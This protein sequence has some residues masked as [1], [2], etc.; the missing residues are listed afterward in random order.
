MTDQLEQPFLDAIIRAPDNDELRRVYADFLEERGDARADLIR[1]QLAGENVERLLEANWQTYA[2]ELAPWTD[3]DSFSRGLVDQVTMTPEQIIE[4]SERVFSRHP[5]QTLKVEVST[6]NAAQ[7]GGAPALSRVR[8]LLLHHETY[9]FPVAAPRPL[10]GIVKGTHFDALRALHFMFCGFDGA[11]WEAFFSELE[12]PLLERLQFDFNRSHP[13]MW[14]ALARNPSLQNLESI[15]EYVTREL[16]GATASGFGAAMHDFAEKKPKLKRL[17]LSQVRT[18]DEANNG[19]NA[20]SSSVV[21]LRE[22]EIDGAK[23]TDA[24]LVNWQRGGRL[25]EL[26]SL[27]VRNSRFTARG[28]EKF[29]E[30][31]PPKLKSLSLH[32]DDRELWTY[33]ELGHLYEAFLRMPRGALET[34]TVPTGRLKG[35]AL[36]IE[37]RRR[38]KVVARE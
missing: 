31:C 14:R 22:L 4:H 1:R 12:A 8:R 26:E 37:L 16:P 30:A 25:G 6:V 27:T 11:D 32:C 28:I 2:G 5:V 18:L 21:Q 33:A 36:W 29:L 35:D 19:S 7:L 38:F 13:A 34:I 20:A 23:L 3:K 10:A 9:E 24:S 15:D 17:R